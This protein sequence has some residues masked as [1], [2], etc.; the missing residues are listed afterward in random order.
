MS[1]DDTPR[2]ATLS[3]AERFAQAQARAGVIAFATDRDADSIRLSFQSGRVMGAPKGW[4]LPSPR[5][6]GVSHAALMA[7]ALAEERLEN[8]RDTPARRN[9]ERL[10]RKALARIRQ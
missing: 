10:A 4:P 3:I 2:P 7:P 6:G 8:A 5:F 1:H 9:A